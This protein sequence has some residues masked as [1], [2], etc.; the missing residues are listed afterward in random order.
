M[1]DVRVWGMMVR[2]GRDTPLSLSGIRGPP[3]GK[4]QAV[5]IAEFKRMRKAAGGKRGE[6]GTLVRK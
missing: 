6:G 5:T 3:E 2:S 1:A 4:D